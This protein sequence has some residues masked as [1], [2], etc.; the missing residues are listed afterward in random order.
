MHCDVSNFT[1]SRDQRSCHRSVGYYFIVSLKF[2][3]HTVSFLKSLEDNTKNWYCNVRQLLQKKQT[4]VIKTLLQSA[5]EVY[6]KEVFYKV[7]QTVSTKCVRYYKE[8]QTVIAK[9]DV[10]ASACN[11]NTKLLHNLFYH[12]RET[13]LSLL[14]FFIIFILFFLNLCCE[15]ATMNNR[16]FWIFK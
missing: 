4:T 8:W 6:Y 7:R 1:W 16:S 10:T 13:F 9:W 11:W 5:T 2:S 15:A 12:P 3:S 14:K